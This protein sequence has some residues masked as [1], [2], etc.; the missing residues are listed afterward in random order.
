M[1]R[2][3]LKRQLA[4]QIKKLTEAEQMIIHRLYLQGKPWMT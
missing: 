2:G 3:I 4:E 1:N